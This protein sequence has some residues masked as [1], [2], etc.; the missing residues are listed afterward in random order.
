MES[1][2]ITGIVMFAMGYIAA[3]LRLVV[4]NRKAEKNLTT[5]EAVLDECIKLRR[6]LRDRSRVDDDN[7]T[8]VQRDT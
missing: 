4:A 8:T 7:D 1:L 5:A 2:L 6:R 3:H